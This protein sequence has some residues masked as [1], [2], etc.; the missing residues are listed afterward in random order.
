MNQAEQLK[1][2]VLSLQQALLN[3]HPTMPQLLR[4]I[5][6]QLKADPTIVTLM[7]EE[8]IGIVVSGLKQ[9]TLTTI[10]TS[11]A[12]SKTKSLKSLSVG[13]L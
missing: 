10:A 1:E 2:S 3:Q 12:K 7:S 11:T 9:Q 8:E 4:Q 13:D 6:Q 5:H